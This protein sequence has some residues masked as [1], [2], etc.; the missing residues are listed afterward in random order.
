M[1][2]KNRFDTLE[3]NP[4][5][6]LGV[7]PT[8]SD[9]EIRRAYFQLVRE[10][11]PER[12]PEQFKRIRAAYEILRDPLQR[13]EW[14]LFVAIQP[15]P[16]LPSRRPLKPDLSLHREDVIWVLRAESELERRNFKR[17]FRPVTPPPIPT[18]T[19]RR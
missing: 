11:P 13:A 4:Y 7:S 8:A 6:V 5:Q 17:D 19:S 18:R 2:S 9:D 15:P 3:E 14:D 16:P 10:H 1:S 12:E